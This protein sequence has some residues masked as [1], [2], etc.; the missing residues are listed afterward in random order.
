MAVMFKAMES[1]G[2][3]GFMGYS[4]GIYEED[5]VDFFHNVLVRENSVVST[6]HGKS[7]QITEEQFSGIFELPTEGLSDLSEV[8][9]D[10]IFDAKS[11]FSKSG[12]QDQ[13]SYKNRKMKYEFR[14]L[15][16]ILAKYVTVK[17]ESFDAVTHERFLLMTAIH[18]GLK[19]N[20]STYIA[21]QMGIDDGNEGDE[22]VMATAALE[23]KKPVT[24]KRTP[25]TAEPI[26]KKKRTTVGRAVPT[27][28]NLDFVC[29]T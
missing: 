29:E 26:A 10:L 2:L 17:A 12:E 8:P 21:K 13:T 4:S 19:I 7:V 22:P 14:L 5:L 18:C 27:D 9:K 25:T 28:K 15:N 6:I 20:C 16:N 24:K 3:R 1:S 11:I 23:K